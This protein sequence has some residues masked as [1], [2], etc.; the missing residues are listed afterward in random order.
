MSRQLKASLRTRQPGQD[1][2]PRASVDVVGREVAVE[3]TGHRDGAAAVVDREVTATERRGNRSEDRPTGLDVEDGQQ[4]AA[5]TVIDDQSLVVAA[6]VHLRGVEEELRDPA[7]VAADPEH[8]LVVVVGHRVV[9]RAGRAR[10]CPG[11]MTCI[12]LPLAITAR[13]VPGSGA[14]WTMSY[15]VD[16]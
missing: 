15:G 7:T 14:P 2:Q 9:G 16:P 3:P 13:C 8:L 10:R 12:R 1:A 6:D 11:R 5:T 4:R